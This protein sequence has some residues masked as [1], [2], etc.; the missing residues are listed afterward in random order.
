MRT[1]KFCS[2]EGPAADFTVTRYSS[3][4]KPHYNGRCRPCY[5]EYAKGRRAKPHVAAYNREYLLKRKY[6]LTL[7]QFDEILASQGG[8]CAICGGTDTGKW[9]N[10]H[11]DHNHITG[12]VR[13][14]LCNECNMAIGKF[15][16]DEGPELLE[17][18]LAYVVSHS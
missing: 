1:C 10:L 15:K 3:D 7:E 2:Y 4:G 5:N 8:A 18:A 6:G 17:K 9:E 13:G 16:T 11:V 12:K 14:I